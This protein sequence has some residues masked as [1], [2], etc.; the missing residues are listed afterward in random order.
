MNCTGLV[1]WKG[2]GNI[3]ELQGVH[4]KP[5]HTN[6][7]AMKEK[8]GRGEISAAASLLSFSAYLEIIY[9][10]QQ[11]NFSPSTGTIC[12]YVL[13]SLWFFLITYLVFSV[14]FSVM[15]HCISNLYRHL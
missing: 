6:V 12:T 2:G 15:L 3:F 1:S 9:I 14:K 13:V 4:F 11:L 7:M 8:E 10:A 5:N